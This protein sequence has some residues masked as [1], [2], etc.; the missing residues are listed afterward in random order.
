MAHLVLHFIVFLVLI[1]TIASSREFLAPDPTTP[2]PNCF[3]RRC[4]LPP[5][6]AMAPATETP[7][8]AP[9]T[10][11]TP[12]PASAGENCFWAIIIRGRC[13]SP[14]AGKG[15]MAAPTP[16]LATATATP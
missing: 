4:Q 14:T 13:S 8:P 9:T 3:G 5:L 1:S 15:N 11:A 2:S 7:V 16:A 10:T 6:A 12:A